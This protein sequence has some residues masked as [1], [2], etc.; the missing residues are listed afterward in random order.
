MKLLII[1]LK[2]LNYEIFVLT[3]NIKGLYPTSVPRMN[4]TMA[5]LH[6]AMHTENLLSRLYFAL[7]HYVHEIMAPLHAATLTVERELPINIII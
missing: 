7:L 6:A 5:S 4:D 3:C 2:K 1:K